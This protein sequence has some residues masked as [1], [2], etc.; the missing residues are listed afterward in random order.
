MAG[1]SGY[2]ESVDERG[3][4]PLEPEIY[5]L[6][7]ALVVA[8]RR[9]ARLE[10]ALKPTGLS[11]AG[12][13]VLRVCNRFGSTTMGELSDYS[14]TDRTTLTRVVDEL[15]A[16]GLVARG[17]SAGDRRKVMLELTAAGR[18]LFQRASNLV[19]RDLLE[20]MR[21]LPQ[22]E[23]RA[24]IRVHQEVVARLAESDAQLERLLWRTKAPDRR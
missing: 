20:L 6:H 9:E 24:A 18:R 3:E 16:A 8:Q 19:S 7:L 10:R 14:L 11:V 17:K 23:L 1:R 2:Y 15:V 22:D 5:F 4:F 21:G 13:R 12:F